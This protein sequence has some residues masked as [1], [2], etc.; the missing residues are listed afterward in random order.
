MAIYLGTNR[1]SP[2]G[3]NGGFMLNGR[4]IATKTYDI[5]LS[6]TNF[7][8]LTPSTTA[9]SL[10]LPATTYTTTASTTVTCHRI[11]EAYGGPPIDPN[12]HDYVVFYEAVID[13]V[14]SSSV[15]GT[16]HGIRS[17]YTRD[18]HH[19][20]S[21]RTIDSTTGQLTTALN[22]TGTSYITSAT[23][24]LYQKADNT[25]AISTTNYGV[26]VS[27]TPAAISNTSGVYYLNLNVGGASVRAHDSY[28]PVEAI[29]A[30]NPTN[31]IIKSTWY[32]YEGDKSMYGQIYDRGY[33][34]VANT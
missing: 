32:I 13:L 24:L 29:Q 22:L 4:L 21:H 7:S 6:D 3:T 9:Q 2:A 34:L 5:K 19:G 8:S 30:I 23:L 17:I 25:Y 31:T 16:I 28:F 27:P 18:F 12:N 10:T 11:G 33:Q 14:Y 20:R 1:V 15:A 26:Y